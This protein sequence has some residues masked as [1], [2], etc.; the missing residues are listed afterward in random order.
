M[1]TWVYF[2][3][4][5]KKKNDCGIRLRICFDTLSE[6]KFDVEYRKQGSHDWVR[7]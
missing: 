7:L 4:D 6:K 3:Q 5:D 1:K 2:T